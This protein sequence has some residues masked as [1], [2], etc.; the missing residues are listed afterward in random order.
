MPAISIIVPLY[1]REALVR[2]TLDSVRQQTFADWECIIVDDGSTDASLE[3]GKQ[4]AYRDARF[5]A[6]PRRGELRGANVCRNQGFAVA[7]G[8]YVLFLDSDDLLA[9]HC[10][11]SRTDFLE[12]RHELDFAVFQ[13]EV[14]RR[15]PGDLGLWY[16][17][18]KVDNDLDRFL[19]M[20]NPW[21]ILHPLWR[22]RTLEH[23][24][25][26]DE[27]LPSWQDWEFSL[28][29]LVMMQR[30]AWGVGPD[31]YCRLGGD[32]RQSIGRAGISQKEVI[33]HEYAV[34][35]VL[36]SLREQ[37]K[38]NQRRTKA[39]ARLYHR[40]AQ[41]WTWL[42]KCEEAGRVWLECRREGL[43]GYRDW[44]IGALCLWLLPKR[45]VSSLAAAGLKRWRRNRQFELGA[46]TKRTL[47]VSP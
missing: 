3:V 7:S 16:N 34:R 38:L 9:P 28:R 14:F 46:T 2:Q 27:C 4:Y 12:Q 13:G 42:G 8:M 43:I 47:F 30:Y 40:N 19:E 33:A 17:V 29:A 41:H 5:K 22:R 39:C 15:T 45:G 10:L 32:G 20:D 24:G 44:M 18:P 26:W 21:V 1:N 25:P 36:H 11:A 23:V 31:T 37:G 6:F 35:K